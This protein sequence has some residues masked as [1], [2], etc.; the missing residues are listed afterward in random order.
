MSKAAKSRRKQKQSKQ[1]TA[2][3]T[4]YATLCLSAQYNIQ[5]CVRILKYVYVWS[6]FVVYTIMNIAMRYY[7]MYVSQITLHLSPELLN[8]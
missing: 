4:Q 5:K 8:R 2:I 1:T 3:K 6:L 7:C